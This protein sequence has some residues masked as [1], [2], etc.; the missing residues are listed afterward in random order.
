MKQKKKK[1]QREMLDLFYQLE[2]KL[3]LKRPGPRLIRKNKESIEEVRNNAKN[4]YE[5]RD[6][7]INT[8]E[9]IKGTQKVQRKKIL[10]LMI[11]C[12]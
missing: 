3:D 8:F 7:I 5:I 9:D 2:Q 4:L 12:I 6:D 1:K 11:Y 10:V